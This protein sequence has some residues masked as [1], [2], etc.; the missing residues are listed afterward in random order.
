MT[1]PQHD[2]A[3]EWVVLL[4]DDEEDNLHMAQLTLEYWGAQVHVGKNGI[5]GLKLLEELDPTVILLDLSMP[6]MNGWVMHEKVRAQEKY[7]TVPVIAL[8]A[9]AMSTDKTKVIEAGFDGYITK[10]FMIDS[11]MERIKECIVRREQR[12]SISDATK[13]G[14]AD[15]VQDIQASSGV[16]QSTTSVAQDS[17]TSAAEKEQ[18]EEKSQ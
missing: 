3:K 8:T 12:Y 9:H 15:T 1:F 10:P 13:N 18:K 16:S 14:T 5:Q 7:N 4:V 2:Y 11:F 6:E 17:Q